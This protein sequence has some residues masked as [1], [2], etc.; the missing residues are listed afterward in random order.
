MAK[1]VVDGGSYAEAVE[2]DLFKRLS[3]TFIRIRI[4]SFSSRWSFTLHSPCAREGSLN[5][6][7]SCPLILE[8]ETLIPF[9]FL[10]LFLLFWFVLP[11][12][13]S[14]V[15]SITVLCLPASHVAS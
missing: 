10:F 4:H 1:K 6:L 5:L 15:T 2:L 12:V 8:T 3:R 9:L 7:L 13:H 14:R 11:V